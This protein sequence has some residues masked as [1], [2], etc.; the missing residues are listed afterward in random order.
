MHR[1]GER[2]Y[3][4][5]SGCEYGAKCPSFR[6]RSDRLDGSYFGFPSDRSFEAGPSEG[7]LDNFNEI[8]VYSANLPA[9]Q[10]LLLSR[11]TFERLL[12]QTFGENQF[13]DVSYTT[14]ND[15]ALLV[16]IH[17]KLS[18]R[19]EVGHGESIRLIYGADGGKQ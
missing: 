16:D 6:C 15:S 14:R 18:R 3:R 1:E 2:D 5:E 8:E 19:V 13:V 4:Q 7:H 11:D 17:L 9:G 10:S 12:F